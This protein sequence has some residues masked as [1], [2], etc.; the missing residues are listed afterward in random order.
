MGSNETAHAG[1]RRIEVF[2]TG[3]AP[4]GQIATFSDADRL[5]DPLWD[6]SSGSPYAACASLGLPRA[7]IADCGLARLR[8]STA[9]IIPVSP[10]AR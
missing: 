2:F 9:L 5:A 3:G 6:R 4:S 1:A 7:R 8:L 10:D